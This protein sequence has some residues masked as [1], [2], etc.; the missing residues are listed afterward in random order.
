M[1]FLFFV[2]FIAFIIGIVIWGNADHTSSV[3]VGSFLIAISMVFS[4]MLGLYIGGRKFEVDEVTLIK[5]SV[6]EEYG[7]SVQ[8]NQ[9]IYTVKR[10]TYKS[11]K[12]FLVN[13][14]SANY[15]LILEDDE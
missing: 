14:K 15:I 4:I 5:T 9:D 2:F 11:T 1:E 7:I 10:T 8:G 13:G 3:N 6:P 12:P